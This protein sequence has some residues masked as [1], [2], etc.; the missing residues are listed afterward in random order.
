MRQ[1]GG[2]LFLTRS[3]CS[4][5]ISEVMKIRV[6]SRSD[7]EWSGQNDGNPKRSRSSKNTNSILHAPQRPLEVQR[8]VTAAKLNRSLARPFLFAC[9]PSHCDGVYCLTRSRNDIALFAS[10]AADGEVRI[11]HLPS[12]SA[13]THIIPPPTAFNRGITFSQ[14]SQRV[15]VCNDAKMVHAIELGVDYVQQP[16]LAKTLTSFKSTAGPLSS[17]S[18]HYHEP[19]FATASS[20]VEIWDENRS[21]PSQSLSVSVDSLHC[22]RF[23]PVEPN[24]IASAGSDRAVTLY[25]IR[26]NT[27]IR[28]LVLKMRSNDISWNPIEAMNFSVANDDHN[29]YTYDMRK[30]SSMGALTV[31]KDHTAAV[32]SIDY[33]PTGR[34][35]VTGSYDKT[36]RIF[37]YNVGVSR[38]IYHTKRMQ[39][40]FAVN[41]S[42]DGA[43]VV[44]GSD[45]GDVRVWKSERSRPLKPLFRDEKEKL[46]M[47]EKLLERY[48]GLTE[49]RKIAKK[50]HLPPHVRSMGITKRIMQDSEKRKESNRRRHTKPEKR[51]KR[52]SG[53]KQNI[54]RELE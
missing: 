25:D 8:A 21:T 54:V 24:I 15:L 45:D 16:E 22:V 35:F 34:E 49:V 50:R 18:A 36:I 10:A 30:L 29:C 28:R 46:D 40:V 52:V 3:S 44:S 4:S 1:F 47:S 6:L 20:V 11:W 27:P 39:R 43:Y 23:N 53:R 31:H 5:N 12:H 32:M 33:S 17:I 51:E 42:L 13:R 38:E 37:P 9:E 48:G 19:K 14:D 7:A 26:A 2:N 41:F